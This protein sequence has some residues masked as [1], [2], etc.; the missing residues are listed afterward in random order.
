[1][2]K[3]RKAFVVLAAAVTAGG[4]C[5]GS[6]T[7]PEPNRPYADAAPIADA[8]KVVRDADAVDTASPKPQPAL[9]TRPAETTPDATPT[10]AGVLADGGVTDADAPDVV[11]DPI[12]V[13]ALVRL[14]TSAYAPETRPPLTMPAGTVYDVISREQLA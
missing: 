7:K 1:M 14:D 2:E 13:D 8:N 9:D 5:G 4:A 6:D 3:T 12:R 11:V 10:D